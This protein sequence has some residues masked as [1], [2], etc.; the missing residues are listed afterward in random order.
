MDEKVGS[1]N[2]E[3]DVNRKG[4]DSGTTKDDVGGKFD[5]HRRKKLTK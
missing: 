5:G 4:L 2:E 3:N 1:V